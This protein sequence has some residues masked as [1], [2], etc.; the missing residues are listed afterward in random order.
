MTRADLLPAELVENIISCFG[1][2]DGL[3]RFLGVYSI[4]EGVVAISTGTSTGTLGYEYRDL[5]DCLR[6]ANHHGQDSVVLV[7]FVARQA[8]TDTFA[9]ASAFLLLENQPA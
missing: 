5:R 4:T 9:A 7:D 6:R 8:W 3:P 1:R 2:T